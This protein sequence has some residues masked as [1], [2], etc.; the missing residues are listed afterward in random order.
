M[1]HAVVRI[2]GQSAHHIHDVGH[3]RRGGRLGPGASSVE[4]ALA[5]GVALNQHRVH[6]AVDAGQQ[7]LLGD[8]GWMHAHLGA[9]R[10][11]TG[12]AQMLDAVSEL[13]GVGHVVAGDAAD[14]LD[15]DLV[16][17][18]RDAEGDGGQDGQLVSGVDA[19]DVESRIGLGVA[20]RLRLGQHLR[21]VAAL[22]AHLGQNEVGGAVD[23]ARHPFDAVAGQALADRLDDRDAAGDRRLEGDHHPGRAGGGEDLVAVPGDQRL[24][25][26]HQVLAVGQRPQRQAARR[27]VA[28][29]QLDDD[30][31]LGIV[32]DLQCLAGQFHPGG[33][34]GGGI[35]IA[36]GGVG[37][38]DFAPGAAADFLGIAGQY[39]GDAA[40]DR[41]QTEQTD[42]DRRIGAHASTPSAGAKSG[43]S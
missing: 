28:A 41:A 15:I 37:D 30:R 2:G 31:D 16:E 27:L 6:H 10:L 12:D 34:R 25:G 11:V 38:D 42:F 29:H 26:G 36:G 40:A 14:A 1:R 22:V 4:Q 19:L 5:D 32:H 8:Q 3:H 43:A 33:I 21:E 39:P 18:Q 24:V 20:Q 7:L 23:D 13:F 17:L 9:V 35:Q